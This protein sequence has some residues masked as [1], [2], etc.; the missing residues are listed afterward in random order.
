MD[1]SN[2][3]EELTAHIQ[4]AYTEGVTMEEAEKL[5]ARFL[6]AQI[7][8]S[9]ALKKVDLDTRMRKVGVKSIKAAVYLDEAK[10]GDKK[11][12]EAALSALVDSNILV[13][14]E[15]NSF[16]Q[17]EVD[18]NELESMLSVARDGHIYYRGIARGRFE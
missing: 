17:A 11:P 15:Q 16:D 4:A 3:K 12:T 7:Q 13:I 14:K 18:R 8:V 10:K 2:L 6:L 1:I 9:E 5:A